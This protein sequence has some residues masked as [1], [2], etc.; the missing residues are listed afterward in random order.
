MHCK[1][2][3]LMPCKSGKQLLQ[4]SAW[5]LIQRQ[6]TV[7]NAEGI[8]FKAKV[9]NEKTWTIWPVCKNPSRLCDM[10][11]I[12]HFHEKQLPTGTGSLNNFFYSI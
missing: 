11:Q 9:K 1:K 12:A 7:K 2:I 8:Y 5:G 4:E 6:V 3:S 10:Q